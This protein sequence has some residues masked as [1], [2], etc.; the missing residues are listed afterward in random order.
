M[1]CILQLEKNLGIDSNKI[2]MIRSEEHDD[3]TFTNAILHTHGT[4]G[5]PSSCKVNWFK[6][7]IKARKNGWIWTDGDIHESRS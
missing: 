1:G 2:I 5:T 4:Y 3:G 7:W 6:V